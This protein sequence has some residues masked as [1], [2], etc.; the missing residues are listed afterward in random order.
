MKELDCECTLFP[1]IRVISPPGCF[2][3]NHLATDEIT[4]FFDIIA[5]SFA[6]FVTGEIYLVY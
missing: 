6:A 5:S 3:T 1:R 4:S 2:V